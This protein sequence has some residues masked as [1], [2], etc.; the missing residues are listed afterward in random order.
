MSAK[1]FGCDKISFFLV[2]VIDCVMK[3]STVEHT[4]PKLFN[5]K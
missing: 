3:Y 2:L 4:E 5:I 1:K